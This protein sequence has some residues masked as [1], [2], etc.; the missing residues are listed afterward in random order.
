MTTLEAR[1]RRRAFRMASR[2][3]AARKLLRLADE[4]ETIAPA[5]AP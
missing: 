3:A 5:P 1:I 2:P 4:A